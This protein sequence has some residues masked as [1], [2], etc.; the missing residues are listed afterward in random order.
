[1]VEIHRTL[2]SLLAD[3]QHIRPIGPLLPRVID[4]SANISER[5]ALADTYEG[6]LALTF[7]LSAATFIRPLLRTPTKL[8]SS[9][10]AHQISGGTDENPSLKI[11]TINGAVI[12]YM[13]ARLSNPLDV[14]IE[15]EHRWLQFNPQ[16]NKT[17]LMVVVDPLDGTSSIGT[18][19]RDQS[20]GIVATDGKER[21]A[22]AIAS[23]VDDELVVVER[24]P[25]SEKPVLT[26]LSFD[27]H[28]G[29]IER[30]AIP[31]VKPKY[32]ASAT[33][34][35]LGRRMNQLQDT[36]LFH[37]RKIPDLPSFGGYVILGLI[38]GQLDAAVDPK[39]QP[40]RE[41][42]MWGG[43]ASEAGLLVTDP[44]GNTINFLSLASEAQ[45]NDAL[46]ET[47]IPIVISNNANLHIQL[48]A[49]LRPHFSTN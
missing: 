8:L 13:A 6:R 14:F 41:V 12:K 11:D 46:M 25:N 9:S 31:A 36:E 32:L 45:N 26:L 39:G 21:F 29:K 35:T 38:R 23:F 20:V 5:H 33:I 43:I 4:R 17:P 47:R 28:N 19:L 15:E 30:L 7:A 18:G 3:R 37:Y 24:N 2:P 27:E 49:S 16:K 48:L 44:E 40:V 22:G 34:A 42:L 10:L 1:M